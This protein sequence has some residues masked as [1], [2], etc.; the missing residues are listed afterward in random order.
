[1]LPLSQ[2][3]LLRRTVTEAL[4]NKRSQVPKREFIMPE[5]A[6]SAKPDGKDHGFLR[7]FTI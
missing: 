7:G 6:Q 2:L 4:E 5:L 1:M 3:N